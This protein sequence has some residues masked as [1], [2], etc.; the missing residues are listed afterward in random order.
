MSND[1]A[2][3]NK[4]KVL[5]YHSFHTSF[6]SNRPY[7][8]SEVHIYSTDNRGF[9]PSKPNKSPVYGGGRRSIYGHKKRN[10][11]ISE[12]GIPFLIAVWPITNAP[13]V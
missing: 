5:S 13:R 1:E 9:L 10:A 4:A 2:K 12:A 3:I 6:L 7:I 11:A 8:N